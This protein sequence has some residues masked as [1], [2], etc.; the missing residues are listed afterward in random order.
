MSGNHVLLV[1]DDR[2][3]SGMVGP[4]LEKEGYRISYAYDGMEAERLFA[5]QPSR[6]DLV[7]L[8]LM[9]PRRSGMEVLREIRSVSL[10]PVL[11]L[12]AKDG[13]VNKALGLELGADDY[14]SKPFSLIELTARVRAAIRRSNY[15][16]PLGQAVDSP[17]QGEVIRV[18]GIVMNLET[19]G[20]ERDGQPVKLTSKEFG[21]LKLLAGHPGRV[22]TKA[23]IYASVWNDAFYGDDNIINV[24]MRRLREKLEA[25]PSDPQY[26]KTLWGLGYK[27]EAD[28]P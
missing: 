7:I 18:G 8:D 15:A 22:Y 6:Y 11:I 1:E 21:I 5:A 13:E 16:V 3:I 24:H 23:Q 10:V 14:V 25:D 12:S 19:Y 26:I 17:E 28:R 4:Y 27:L 2:S 9:L 20:V